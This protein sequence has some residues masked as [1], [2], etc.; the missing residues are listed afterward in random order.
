MRIQN[1]GARYLIDFKHHALQR[2]RTPE[3][4][5]ILLIALTIEELRELGH[6]RAAI[7]VVIVIAARSTPQPA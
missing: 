5:P 1:L 4:E 7:V 3:A 2:N 6:R